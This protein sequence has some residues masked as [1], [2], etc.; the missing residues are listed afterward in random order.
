VCRRV[1][2]LEANHWVVRS[3]LMCSCVEKTRLPP[4]RFSLQRKRVLLRFER[5]ASRAR[6]ALLWG[7]RTATHGGA[8]RVGTSGDRRARHPG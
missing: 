6:D 5:S 7:N 8:L 4:V 1:A 2:Y 3:E